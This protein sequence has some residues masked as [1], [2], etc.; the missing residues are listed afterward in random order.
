MI[1]TVDDD[2]LSYIARQ[3]AIPRVSQIIPV[4]SGNINSTFLLQSA[5]EKIILQQINH[6][7]FPEPKH[8]AENSYRVS[9]HIN[10]YYAGSLWVPKILLSVDQRCY[11]EDEQGGIWRAQQYVRD[12]VTCSSTEKKWPAFEL[13]RLLGIF[14]DAVS[15]LPV[16]E[17]YEVLPGFHDLPGYLGLYDKVKHRRDEQAS[18]TAGLQS[19]TDACCALIASFRTNE[20][21]VDDWQHNPN[22]RTRVIHGDPKLSNVLFSEKKRKAVTLI[23]L[24]TV[25][26]GFILTDIGDMLRSVAQNGKD[27]CDISLIEAALAGY[28]STSQAVHLTEYEKKSIYAALFRISFELGVRFFTDYLS[29]NIYFSVEYPEQS[30][31]RAFTQFTFL[32]HIETLQETLVETANRQIK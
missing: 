4:S 1:D 29:G 10:K 11:V 6:Y 9:Y 5:A 28:F 16:E 31:D 15:T 2:L 21:V 25:G 30:L 20:L 27:R 3:Y 13:G 32:E 22:M 23:D 26:A 19:K 14:H 8:V 12:G 24:D 18:G 7:V 17:M